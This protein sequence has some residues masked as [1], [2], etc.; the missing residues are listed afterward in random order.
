VG[1]IP[2]A[3]DVV[4][5]CGHR[6]C[7]EAVAAW[8][9]LAYH[10]PGRDQARLSPQQLVEKALAGNADALRAC[11]DLGYY[12]GKGLATLVTVLNPDVIIIG[13]DIAR[14]PSLFQDSLHD[15]MTRFSLTQAADQVKLQFAGAAHHAGVLGAA[16]LLV[17]VIYQSC[18]PATT[19][20]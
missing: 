12:L 11:A 14:F 6:G 3:N 13:G 4:C 9:A 2:V 17:P 8:P 7:L 18:I 16:G 19:G 10:M 5:A 20:F 1:H 15:S